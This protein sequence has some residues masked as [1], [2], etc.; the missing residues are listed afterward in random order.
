MD[1]I[2]RQLLVETR[3]GVNGELKIRGGVRAI[4]LHWKD[5]LLKRI[6]I[7]VKGELCEGFLTDSH[8]FGFKPVL[9]H[10]FFHLCPGFAI[11]KEI[12]YFV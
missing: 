5:I 1:S 3:I 7:D 4:K 8:K 12:L 11:P 6:F 10:E 9:L 2:D